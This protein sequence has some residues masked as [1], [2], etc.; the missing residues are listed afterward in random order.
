[1][2]PTRHAISA[3]STH[4]VCSRRDPHLGGRLRETQHRP[5]QGGKKLTAIVFQSIEGGE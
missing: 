5:A 3:T 1:M 4:R 2:T